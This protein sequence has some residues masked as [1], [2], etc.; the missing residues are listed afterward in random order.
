MAGYTGVE[1]KS[2]RGIFATLEQDNGWTGLALVNTE[3]EAA[4]VTLRA[5]NN[6]GQLKARKDLTLAP[7][8]RLIGLVTTI[9]AREDI[10]EAHYISYESN[11]E[12]VGFQINGNGRLLDALPALKY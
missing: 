11:R 12:L 5:R 4:T 3:S 2:R 6:R 8:E 7:H 1:L 9:F 10:S